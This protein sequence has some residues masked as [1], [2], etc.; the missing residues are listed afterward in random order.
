MLVAASI[1]EYLKRN[2]LVITTAESCTAGKI[3]TLLSEV[4]GGGHV[5]R[6]VM[7]SIRQKRNSDY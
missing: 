6:A 7:L 3:I 4:D 5:L 1:V 2:R